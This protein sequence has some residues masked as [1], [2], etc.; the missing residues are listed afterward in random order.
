MC[1]SSLVNGSVCRVA[2]NH[3]MPLVL[4]VLSFQ[5][6]VGCGGLSDVE[7]SN[8]Q[9]KARVQEA[10]SNWDNPARFQT[11]LNLNFNQ[12]PT[13]G[14]AAKQPWSA[15]FWPDQWGGISFRWQTNQYLNGVKSVYNARNLSQDEI[16]H[17]LSPSEKF[18]LL[19]GR[20]HFP[21]TESELDKRYNYKYQWNGMC[22]AWSSAAINEPEPGHSA[23]LYNYAGQRITFYRDDIKALLIKIYDPPSGQPEEKI[24]LGGQCNSWS[25]SSRSYNLWCRDN[26]PGTLHVVLTNL[27]GLQK[28]SFII[29]KDAT[30]QIWNQPMVSYSYTHGPVK[31]FYS[32]SWRAYYRSPQTRYLVEVDLTMEYVIEPTDFYGK[33]EA[34]TRLTEV[35]NLKYSLEL[36]ANYNIVGGE[37]Y[38]NQAFPDVIW[39]PHD[40]PFYNSLIP[41]DKVREILNRSLGR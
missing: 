22:H 32:N 1:D 26:N 17:H 27:M 4:M 7:D 19:L 3:L 37:W 11:N 25:R 41:Y 13:S 2:V 38:P 29:D 5:I 9:N 20:Y 21:L 40:R 28:K 39:L 33:I 14:R 18:D 30:K 8:F 35:K 15:H 34:W 36:D 12:L 31:S 24:F 10:W 6:F 23:T 16:N